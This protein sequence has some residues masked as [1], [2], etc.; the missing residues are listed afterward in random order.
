MRHIAILGGTFDPIHNGHLQTALAIQHFFHFACF[1]LLPCNVPVLKAKTIAT[2]QQRIEMISLAI[3]NLKDF[4]LDLREINR[5]TPSYMTET[6]IDI[7]AQN[8][9]TAI[10]LVLGYDAFLSLPLWHNWDKIIQLTNLLIIKRAGMDQ[11][12]T[13]TLDGFLL[14]HRTTNKEELLHSPYGK[15]YDFN[16]GNYPIS[17]TE[18]KAKLAKREEV[19]SLMPPQVVEYINK[20]K[21]YLRV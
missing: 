14:Q 17:S 2:N 20:Y 8:P 18:I 21:L 9:D 12:L 5:S 11:P 6:L 15:I 7:R 4:A 13:P 10:S 3:A 1:Y 16:A 19:A